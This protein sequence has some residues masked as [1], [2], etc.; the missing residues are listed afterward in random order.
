MKGTRLRALCW[1]ERG[2]CC[3]DGTSLVRIVPGSTH[4]RT[5]WLLVGS[6]AAGVGSG[7]PEGSDEGGT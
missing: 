1:F 6:Y 4:M 3:S 5:T 2:T 7:G